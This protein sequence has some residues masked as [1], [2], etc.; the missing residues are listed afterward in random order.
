MNNK[1]V[2]FPARHRKK[3]SEVHIRAPHA[4][5]ENIDFKVIPIDKAVRKKILLNGAESLVVLLSGKITITTDDSIHGLGPRKDVFASRAASFYATGYKSLTLTGEHKISQCAI[6]SI[7]IS[8]KEKPFGHEIPPHKVGTKTVGTTTSRRKVHTIFH[9]PSM[10][11]Q[12][13]LIVGETFNEPG[14]W[15]SFPP[16]KHA[17]EHPPRETRYE[18]IYFF[19]VAPRER[20]GMMRVYGGKTDDTYAI[21]DEDAL[22]VTD[23]YHPLCALPDTTLYYLW[24]L[25]GRN[26]DLINA[27]DPAFQ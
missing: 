25:Y 8:Q 5:I 16:H 10:R 24:V 4:A 1:P 3:S 21:Y 20:F 14:K 26:K 9:G 6:I 12:S 17:L 23:G 7:P 2:Y 15:S 11:F 22:I 18:E 19:K 13:H 27:Y